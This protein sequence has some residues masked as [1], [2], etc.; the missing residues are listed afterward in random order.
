MLFRSAI[1]LPYDITEYADIMVL[2]LEAARQ[3]GFSADQIIIATEYKMVE[4]RKRKW[5]K[6]DENGVI[7]HCREGE[8]D[9]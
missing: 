7:L 8:A 2:F 4:N 6:P 3:A 5:N 1:K 9:V